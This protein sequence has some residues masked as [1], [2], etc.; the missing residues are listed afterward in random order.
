ML[1]DV[2]T[3]RLTA[4]GGRGRMEEGG[5]DALGGADWEEGRGEETPADGETREVGRCGGCFH[6]NLILK[7]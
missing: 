7:M 2:K 4:G 5:L 1:F 6:R 3:R